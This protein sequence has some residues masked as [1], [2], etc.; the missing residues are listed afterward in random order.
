[1]TYTF[2]YVG[3]VR[4]PYLCIYGLSPVSIPIHEKLYCSN[5]LPSYSRV[6]FG[7]EFQSCSPPRP[8]N[9]MN[10]HLLI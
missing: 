4:Q 6:P 5:L 10:Q 3:Q 1:M 9:S 2:Y 8:L 7:K